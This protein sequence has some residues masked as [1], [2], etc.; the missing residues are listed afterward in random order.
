MAKRRISFSPARMMDALV[1]GPGGGGAWC[2]RVVCGCVLCPP[3]A[4][5]LPEP[6]PPPAHTLHTHPSP[7]HTHPAPAPPPPQQPGQ[8]CSSAS[9]TSQPPPRRSPAARWWGVGACVEGKGWLGR[10]LVRAATPPPPPHVLKDAPIRRAVCPPAPP[11]SHRDVEGGGLEDVSQHLR[12]KGCAWV[13]GR[14][15]RRVKDQGAGGGLDGVCMH[16]CAL[17]G[18][19]TPSPCPGAR[20]CVGQHAESDGRLAQL[21]PRNV[22][23]N[24]GTHQHLLK[25]AA[26]GGWAYVRGG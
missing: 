1:L 14:G 26:W 19:H 17:P 18:P 10:N 8:Q 13:G 20:L 15:H 9:R 22:N 4:Q 6:P 23:S 25:S 11:P 16:A 24:V 2:A 21:P 7:L 3:L 5:P 12:G